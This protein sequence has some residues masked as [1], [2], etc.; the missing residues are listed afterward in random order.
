MKVTLGAKSSESEGILNEIANLKVE[1]YLACQALSSDYAEKDF[2]A[3][4]LCSSKG[5]V[6]D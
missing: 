2:N 6:I 4:F 5:M 3:T 1:F